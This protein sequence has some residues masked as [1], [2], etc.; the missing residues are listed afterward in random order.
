[1][2][3]TTKYRTHIEVRNRTFVD[4]K[5]KASEL[6]CIITVVGRGTVGLFLNI[7]TVITDD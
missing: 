4:K 7:T 6:L 5:K 3:R 2:Y 1:M